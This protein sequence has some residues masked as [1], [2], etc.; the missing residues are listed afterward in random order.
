MNIRK[1]LLCALALSVIGGA[2][3]GANEA[4]Q[5]LKAKKVRMTVNGQ[6]LSGGALLSIDGK[7]YVPL[8]SVSDTLQALI[9]SDSASESIHIYKPN[10]HLLLFTGDKNGMLAFGKVNKRGVYEFNVQAQVDNLQTKAH[11]IKTTVVDPDGQ[12]VETQVYKL[13]DGDVRDGVFWYTTSPIRL[14][15][16]LSGQYKVKFYIK[17]AED[18]EFELVSEKAIISALNN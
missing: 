16:K 13:L 6:E 10:V 7:T 9:K 3:A 2:S 4:Y 1:L 14:D 8:R 17:Q 12:T 5:S 15:F 11:S 18:S